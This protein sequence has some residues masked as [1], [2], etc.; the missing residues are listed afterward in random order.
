MLPDDSPPP[1]LAELF[2]GGGM[3]AQPDEID[4]QPHPDQGESDE[5]L[6][7]TAIEALQEAM[8]NEDDTAASATLA[9][10]I[11]EL[12]KLTSGQEDA[13]MS[14]MGGNPKTMRAM[15]RANA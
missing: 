8:Q 5:D 14:A 11:Q 13:A 10:V 15:Q 9:K 1:G 2:S 12:Y 6:V 4:V 3:D 7:T